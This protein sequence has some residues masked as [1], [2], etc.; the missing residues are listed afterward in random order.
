[1]A[2]IWLRHL[3]DD[4]ELRN[5]WADNGEGIPSAEPSWWELFLARLRSFSLGKPDEESDEPALVI[6][7]QNG[8]PRASSARPPAATPQQ[9]VAG[10]SRG[11]APGSANSLIPRIIGGGSHLASAR[12]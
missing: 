8:R 11:P 9:T 1:M 2:L 10:Q 12:C 4:R 7:G 6:G 5:G 3:R